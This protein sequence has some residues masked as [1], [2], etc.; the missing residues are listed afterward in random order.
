[1]SV[2]EI[3]INNL[4]FFMRNTELE[5]VKDY[6]YLGVYFARSWSFRTRKYLSER[7]TNK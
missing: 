3:P 2:E 1:M 7:A 5:I 6:K 4:K